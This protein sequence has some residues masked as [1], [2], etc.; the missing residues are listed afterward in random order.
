[1]ELEENAYQSPPKHPHQG[2]AAFGT[3][4]EAGESSKVLQFGRVLNSNEVAERDGAIQRRFGSFHDHFAPL[5]AQTGL[6]HR[7]DGPP[8]RSGTFHRPS[9]PFRRSPTPQSSPN[10]L[11]ERPGTSASFQQRANSAPPQHYED[12]IDENK[13]NISPIPDFSA[14]RGRKRLAPAEDCTQNGQKRPKAM[15]IELM[16]S[17]SQ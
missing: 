3:P 10:K 5:L 11:A 4:R 2:S 1:M 17:E 8:Q 6:L 14:Q 9:V 15:E 16:D 7:P 13:E 12:F